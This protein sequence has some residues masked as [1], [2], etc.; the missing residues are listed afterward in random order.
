MDDMSWLRSAPN[1][2]PKLAYT[3]WGILKSMSPPLMARW[4]AGELPIEITWHGMVWCVRVTSDPTTAQ[5]TL[6][7][8][9]GSEMHF[10]LDDPKLIVQIAELR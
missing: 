8:K 10:T 2:D 3:C 7:A 4:L 5:I 1:V 6:R 9:S